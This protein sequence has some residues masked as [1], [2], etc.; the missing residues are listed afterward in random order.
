MP[1]ICKRNMIVQSHLH[2][3]DGLDAPHAQ[4]KMHALVPDRFSKTKH[5]VQSWAENSP[6]LH[7]LVPPNKVVPVQTR[8]EYATC[9]SYILTGPFTPRKLEKIEN[10]LLR[11]RAD[12]EFARE[13]RVWGLIA[14]R[15]QGKPVRDDFA[16]LTEQYPTSRLCFLNLC[17]S[18]FQ[19]RE[20]DVLNEDA[21]QTLRSFHQA[22]YLSVDD[23]YTILM[24]T[25]L[26]TKFSISTR[27][28]ME[29]AIVLLEHLY[30]RNPAYSPCIS[31]MASLFVKLNKP[32]AA[33]NFACEALQKNASNVQAQSIVVSTL[34]AA[35]E[36]L[37]ND[38]QNEHA[39][40][41]LNMLDADQLPSRTKRKPLY[42]IPIDMPANEPAAVLFMPYQFQDALM[43]QRHAVQGRLGID[44][45]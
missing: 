10:K 25:L 34:G 26:L 40:A 27:Q 12:A 29:I 1:Q 20:F 18:Y 28:S 41:L 4:G 7:Q 22:P 43:T 42:K 15:L 44:N 36:A 11:V 24:K 37:K 33:L 39:V 16:E 2:G 13:A 32:A 35:S 9:V 45:F 17:A 6:I 31:V 30:L 3:S 5:R 23:G 14:R 21:L 8:E 19:P 38:P